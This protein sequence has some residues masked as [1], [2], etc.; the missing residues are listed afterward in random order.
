MESIQDMLVEIGAHLLL[1]YKVK[2]NFC[3]F[4]SFSDAFIPISPVE[5]EDYTRLSLEFKTLFELKEVAANLPENV[6]TFLGREIQWSKLDKKMSEKHIL[7][8]LASKLLVPL[9]GKVTF[10][11]GYIPL[12]KGLEGMET[13]KIGIGSKYTLHGTPDLRLEGLLFV[14]TEDED[15]EEEGEVEASLSSAIDSS[16]KD[17]LCVHF[18]FTKFVFRCELRCR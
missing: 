3:T 11:S 12:V 15:E 18:I 17:Q 8:H 10:E 7:V 14:T 6:K 5:V 1:L 9:F 16:G 4:T 2:K 13:S